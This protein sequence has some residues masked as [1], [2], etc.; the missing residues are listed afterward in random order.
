MENFILLRNAFV[1]Q[2]LSNFDEFL[3]ARNAFLPEK[4]ELLE[5]LCELLK[6]EGR[7]LRVANQLYNFVRFAFVRQHA[8][9]ASNSLFSSD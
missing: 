1:F 3:V 2:M 6:M 4:A 9:G 5:V 7:F 8:Y